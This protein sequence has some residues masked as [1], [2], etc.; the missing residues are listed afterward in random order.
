M[1]ISNHTIRTWLL[2][3]PQPGLRWSQDSLGGRTAAAAPTLA[4]GGCFLEATAKASLSPTGFVPF[5]NPALLSRDEIPQVGF[6]RTHLLSL[7]CAENRGGKSGNSDQRSKT[8]YV[9]ITARVSPSWMPDSDIYPLSLL[10]LFPTT[11]HLLCRPHSPLRKDQPRPL[12]S[13]TPGCEVRCGNT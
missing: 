10:S 7:S 8:V 6:I 3:A 9:N 2:S 12:L 5:M 4:A 11:M 1:K 13:R